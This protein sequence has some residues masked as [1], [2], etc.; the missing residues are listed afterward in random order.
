[1]FRGK[2]KKF[3]NFLKDCHGANLV[4]YLILVGVISLIALAGFKTFGKKVDTK[5]QDQGNKVSEIG[6]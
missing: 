5:I 6:N 2:M 4:E 1:M 3:T